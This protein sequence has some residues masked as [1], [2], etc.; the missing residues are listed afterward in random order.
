MKF[1]FEYESFARYVL[2]INYTKLVIGIMFLTIGSIAFSMLTANVYAQ[3]AYNSGYDHGC[4]DAKISDPDDRYINQ[5]GKGPRNHTSEF[6]DGYNRG[7]KDCSDSENEG[8]K[9]VA[10]AGPNREIFEGDT[11]TLDGRDSYDP[12]GEIVHYLWR[13]GD[14]DDP[15]C[16]NGSFADRNSATPQFTAPDHLIKE[17]HNLYDLDVT[18]DDG[19]KDHGSMIITV[20]PR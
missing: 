7:F 13:S 6:M 12:D 4:D 2:N 18:D 17:C 16:P 10:D 19:N 1:Y 8:Q 5:P 3:S 9:P 11:I 20:K 15:D 14:N